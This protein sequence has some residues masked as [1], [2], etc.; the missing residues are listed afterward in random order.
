[1]RIDRLFE[2]ARGPIIAGM[3]NRNLKT[4]FWRNAAAS[5]P[6]EVRSRYA[7]DIERAERWELALGRAIELLARARAAFGRTF[8]APRGAH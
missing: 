8:H 7:L 6:V 4:A 1:V 5:L 3:K 2:H